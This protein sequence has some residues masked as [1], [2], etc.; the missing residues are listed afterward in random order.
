[1][2]SAS[3]G[4]KGPLL[5]AGHSKDEPAGPGSAS[6]QAPACEACFLV[7]QQGSLFIE[8]VGDKQSLVDRMTMHK[9]ELTAGNWEL[10][11]DDDGFACLDNTSDPEG[12]VVLVEDFMD[13]TLW[14]TKDGEKLIKWR[15]KKGGATSRPASRSPHWYRQC[16]SCCCPS[17][18]AGASPSCRGLSRPLQ[19]RPSPR[20]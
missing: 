13:K 17:I 11:F 16:S 3:S 9:Q 19:S 5:K 15:H 12:E 8:R 6:M 20:P 7:P 1:M 18:P 10:V 4:D 2:P 14:K